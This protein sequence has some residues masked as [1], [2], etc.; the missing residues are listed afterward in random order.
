MK[1]NLDDK[2][3][4]GWFSK[5]FRRRIRGPN[6]CLVA[7]AYDPVTKRTSNWAVSWKLDDVTRYIGPEAAHENIS[8][9]IGTTSSAK[10]VILF[11]GHGRPAGL[12]TD[13]GLGK[14]VSVVSC[15]LHGALL[16][17]DDLH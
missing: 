14:E 10:K 9:Q 13:R 16:D 6:H 2:N 12:L 3:R 1:K 17:T 11:I 5:L 7:P 15:P 4:N 8:S